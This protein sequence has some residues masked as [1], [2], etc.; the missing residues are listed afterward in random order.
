MASSLRERYEDWW[1][2]LYAKYRTTFPYQHSRL[3]TNSSHNKAEQKN[4]D[5]VKNKDHVCKTRA[6]VRS[7]PFISTWL[8]APC[9]RKY[10]RRNHDTVNSSGIS[11]L[12][13][14]STRPWNEWTRL[15]V[16]LLS[17][18]RLSIRELLLLLFL[19]ALDT[20]CNALKELC[21]CNMAREGLLKPGILLQGVG[22]KVKWHYLIKQPGALPRNVI[23]QEAVTI[24]SLCTWGRVMTR[25]TV[26]LLETKQFTYFLSVVIKTQRRSVQLPLLSLDCLFR[27]KHIVLSRR[28]EL[29]PKCMSV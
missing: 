5:Y 27:R 1:L 19:Y 24:H 10:H 18:K 8:S 9:Y 2:H 14:V 20:R 28:L 17:Q 6:Q 11:Q 3:L 29:K 4:V 12:L 22:Q 21:K 23:K 13:Q 16:L 7:V 15:G 25:T 26:L